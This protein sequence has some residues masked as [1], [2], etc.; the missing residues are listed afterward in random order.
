[1]ERR[2]PVPVRLPRER[3]VHPAAASC[4][5]CRGIV[6]R[7]IGEDITDT[8]EHVPASC[9]VIQHI[10]YKVLLPLV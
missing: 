6:L 7:K 3:L 9:K 4:P 5:C 1:M 10:R 8:L 2:G